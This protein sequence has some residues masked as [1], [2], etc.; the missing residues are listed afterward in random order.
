[1]VDG[2]NIIA[3]RTLKRKGLFLMMDHYISDVLSPGVGLM[4]KLGMFYYNESNQ[5]HQNF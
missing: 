5:D 2:S 3:S 1:M 4:A